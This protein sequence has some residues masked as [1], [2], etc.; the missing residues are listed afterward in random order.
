M[1]VGF[2]APMKPPNHPSPSGDR[3]LAQLLIEAI[4]LTGHE[5]QVMSEFRSLDISGDP[6]IQE[7]IEIQGREEAKRI[8]QQINS[9]GCE[10][11]DLWFTYHLFHKA[12]DWLG[13][14][15]SKTLGI[16][17]VVAEAS[18]AP[19]QQMGPWQTGLTR[20]ERALQSADG[21]ISLNPRDRHCIQPFLNANVIQSS[22]LPFTRQ[23]PNRQEKHDGLKARLGQH[24]GADSRAPWLIVVAMMRKGDKEHSFRI[25]ASALAQ[26]L[27]LDWQL[28][29]IGSGD[30]AD[31][32]QRAF[33]PIGEDRVHALGVL[34]PAETQQYLDASDIFVWPAV[35][36]AFGMAMLEAHRHGLPVVA[37]YTDGTA[38]IVEDQVTG[39]LTEPENT[40]TFAQAVRHLLENRNLRETME[41]NAREKF[42]SNH[43]LKT[44][45][46]ALDRFLRSLTLP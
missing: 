27:D 39:F 33:G 17:Y 14:E 30:A 40:E 32:V 38:T 41:R 45:A 24:L 7:N 16:P 26:I 10:I 36:E 35:N 3:T 28:M 2:Y 22:L 44:A 37:G 5:V 20:V 4:T 43:T 13:P 8:L 18:Y 25:L 21:V 11:I 12:P 6:D 29:L 46:R 19:K 1:R 42:L 9:N 34:E 15:I 31:S 23:L